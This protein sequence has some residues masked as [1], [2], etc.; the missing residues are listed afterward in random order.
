MEWPIS[1]RYLL[2]L[3]LIGIGFGTRATS[4]EI[5]LRSDSRCD[6][7]ANLVLRNYTLS[8]TQAKDNALRTFKRVR[9]C[10]CQNR[11]LGF[12]LGISNFSWDVSVVTLKPGCSMFEIQQL[13][14]RIQGKSAE[15]SDMF[16]VCQPQSERLITGSVVED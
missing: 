3:S 14:F 10:N 13:Q 9:K 4:K 7:T 6:V 16:Q 8:W 12:R 2:S 11:L 1:Y 15:W 5:M